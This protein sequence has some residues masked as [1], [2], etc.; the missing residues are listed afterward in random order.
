M[1]HM[2]F[3]A[4]PLCDKLKYYLLPPFESLHPKDQEKKESFPNIPIV[5][6]EMMTQTCNWQLTTRRKKFFT[7]ILSSPSPSSLC[8]W[9]W[10]DDCNSDGRWG[11][12]I[13]DPYL[14]VWQPRSL[15]HKQAVVTS[16]LSPPSYKPEWVKWVFS[17]SVWEQESASKDG[18]QE[19]EWL[20]WKVI[21]DLNLVQ[22][23]SHTGRRNNFEACAELKQRWDHLPH[24]NP[25]GL[26]R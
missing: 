19:S 22:C 20:Y 21:T 14:V 9:R 10:K 12:R 26:L 11:H 15:S 3:P 17:I 1:R 24:P 8:I 18:Y 7:N 6:L 23:H 16:T 4:S 5:S 25:W 13:T 2:N